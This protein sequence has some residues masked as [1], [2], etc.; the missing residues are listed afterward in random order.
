MRL[1][2][3]FN[4]ISH[5]KK[6]Q[7]FLKRIDVLQA[8]MLNLKLDGL[9]IEFEQFYLELT[10]YFDGLSKV[11]KTQKKGDDFYLIKKQVGLTLRQIK[12][13]QDENKRLIQFSE[14]EIIG[15]FEN[16]LVLK[17]ILRRQVADL[18]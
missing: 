12:T 7:A 9:I 11:L 5:T 6:C 16:Q 10:N 1:I 15:Y 8:K 3:K 13:L 14:K 17:K 2:L 4:P 18:K